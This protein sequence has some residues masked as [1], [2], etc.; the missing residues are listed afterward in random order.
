MRE[1]KEKN[2][3]K[4]SP[5]IL[6]PQFL[7]KE[8]RFHVLR[9][10]GACLIMESIAVPSAIEMPVAETEEESWEKNM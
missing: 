10:L 7:W 8:R 9:V 5:H 1:Q 3:N 2:S 4:E 6:A